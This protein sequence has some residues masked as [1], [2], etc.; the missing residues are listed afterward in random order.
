[1]PSL[2]RI[3][4]D[5]LRTRGRGL[6]NALAKR[7]GQK[8]VVF[9]SDDWGS[10]RVPSREAMQRL[11]EKNIITGKS[12]YDRESLESGE[13]IEVLC[14]TLSTVR[15][16]AGSSAV[17]T[18]FINPANPDF[19]KIRESGFDRYFWEPNSQTLERRGDL[20]EVKAA[21]R[22]G[23]DEGLLDV[24]FHGREHLQVALWME[25]LR[26][27]PVVRAAF[28]E[29]YYSVQLDELPQIARGFRAAYF[30]RNEDEITELEEIIQSGALIFM[31]EYGKPAS[32]FCPPNNIFHPALYAAVE[33][34]GCKAI[35]RHMR[36]VQPD[37][38]GGQR[39]VWGQW[40][41]EEAGLSWYG[42][43]V[44]FEP[45]QGYGLQHTFGQIKS[46]FA[47]G[48]PAIISSHRVNYVG[49][50]DPC[51]RERGNNALKELLQRITT[52]WPDVRFMSSSQLIQELA[53][54]D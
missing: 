26:M 47:W 54:L 4:L 7:S 53:T 44:L 24:E 41:V 10:Q 12:P 9:E 52:S 32:I 31:Q 11:I 20:I 36:N 18:C 42:R 30:F 46:A 6:K 49:G 33:L 17:F 16:C 13:D 19:E 21:W 23:R 25:K 8:I 43:N 1:M 14:E 5:T 28:E 40:G 38:Q 34:A 37:G 45:E 39:T 29:G 2:S 15:D 48:V 3:V 35:I 22:T 50:I 51:V 27:N